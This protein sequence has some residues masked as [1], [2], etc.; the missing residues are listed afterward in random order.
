M[1]NQNKY[2]SLIES[3]LKHQKDI[4]TYFDNFLIENIYKGQPYFSRAILTFKNFL[5]SKK[6][7]FINFEKR[8][9]EK[10]NISKKN[11]TSQMS[12]L[13]SQ[14]THSLFQ[15]KNYTVCKSVL[16]LS[17]Y[18]ML[19][20]KL[21]PDVIVEIGSG[22]GGSAV[23]LADMMN[24]LGLKPNVYSYDIN[25]P[26]L[27]YPGVNFFKFDLHTLDNKKFPKHKDW[28]G[29]KLIIE[30][31]HVNIPVVL[32]TI[33]KDLKK[34]DYF[35]IED[36]FNKQKDVKN[37]ILKSKNK[38]VLDRYFLDFFG[39]NGTSAINSIFKRI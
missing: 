32:D 23:W 14:G 31:A 35:I 15:W 36:S 21:K 6:N 8:T 37:F 11:R 22:T 5:K 34:G 18:S 33:D 1:L 29:V 3:K 7:R 25:K 20:T 9:K 2:L 13:L 39:F 16:D 30:D 24:V 27:K 12:V 19:I 17:I 28:K 26:S 38:Y 4:P 10:C